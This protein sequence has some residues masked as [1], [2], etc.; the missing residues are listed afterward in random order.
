[1]NRKQFLTKSSLAMLAAAGLPK[2]VFSKPNSIETYKTELKPGVEKQLYYELL[3]DHLGVSYFSSAKPE[4]KIITLKTAYFETADFTKQT[5]SAEFKYIMQECT[6]PDS[7]EDIWKIKT[8]LDKKVSGD[9]LLP[10]DFPKDMIL[11]GKPYTYYDILG[12]KEQLLIHMPYSAGNSS[13]YDGCFLTTACVEHKQLADDCDELNTLRFLRDNYMK[14]D[15]EGA[16]LAANYKII[17][18]KI[19]QTINGFDNRKDIYNYMY[20]HLVLPSVKMIK[21]KQY[22]E[23]TNYYKNFVEGLI[24]QYL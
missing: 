21:A 4:E 14:Q 24:K 17:G 7:N 23:A 3:I 11:S 8:K 10:K 20:D 18:P 22:A 1:M 5:K 12:K 16:V 13:D 9:L 6:K 19:V 15:K 2:A